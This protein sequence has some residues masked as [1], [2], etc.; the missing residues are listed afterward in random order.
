[1][2]ETSEREMWERLRILENGH[3]VL[4]AQ[5]KFRDE[6]LITIAKDFRDHVKM[7]EQ[8]RQKM[9]DDINSVHLKLRDYFDS[10]MDE[11]ASDISKTVRSSDAVKAA[12]DGQQKLFDKYG[13]A[14]VSGAIVASACVGTVLAILKFSG[15]L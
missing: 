12:V 5:S 8:E 11:L 2:D 4:E 15:K 13:P 7:Q 3:S 14:V 9:T 1:M 6:Q 10:K